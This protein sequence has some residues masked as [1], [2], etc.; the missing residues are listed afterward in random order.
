MN[1]DWNNLV[2]RCGN[3]IQGWNHNITSGE[4]DAV[5]QVV[6]NLAQDAVR[7]AHK[8]QQILR[9][10]ATTTQLTNRLTV[11][12]QEV[13]DIKTTSEAAKELV[14]FLHFELIC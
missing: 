9:L 5:V 7:I 6:H 8:D 11:K 4:A 13:V 1:P 10:T 14:I 2:N 3:R 12:T